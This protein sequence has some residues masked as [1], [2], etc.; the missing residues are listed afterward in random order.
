MKRFRPRVITER[1]LRSGKMPLAD[2]E[3]PPDQF[4]DRL[5]KYIPA[6][7]VGGYIVVSGF[8]EGLITEK[9]TFMHLSPNA[10][11][12][13][14]MVTFCLL[15]FIYMLFAPKAAGEPLPWFQAFSAPV[16]FL[17]WS[18]AL[19]GPFEKTLPDYNKAGAAIL[20]VFVSLIIPALDL[21]VDY[22]TRPKGTT[23]APPS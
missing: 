2:S 8:V 10:C 18:F 9:R 6:E 19:G 1:S 7:V 16:A 14:V 4:A 12:W 17:T 23:G 13:I 11:L 22:F 21:A 3:G 15:A 5:L 20:L